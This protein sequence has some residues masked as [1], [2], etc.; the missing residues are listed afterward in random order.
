MIRHNTMT[1]PHLLSSLLL[2][3]ALLSGCDREQ[4]ES[5][6]GDADTTAQQDGTTP[7]IRTIEERVISAWDESD[8]VDSPVFWHQDDSTAIVIAT[9]KETDQLILYDATNGSEVGRVGKSGSGPGEFMRPNG[10][11]LA[12]DL[13]FVV[14]RDN[15][16]V[17][18]LHLPEFTPLGSFGTDDL[19]KPYGIALEGFEGDVGYAVVTDN[20]ETETGQVPSDSLLDRRIRRYRITVKG[21]TLTTDLVASFGETEGDGVLR[22]VESIGFDPEYGRMLVVE[23]DETDTH[24]KIYGID[25]QYRDTTFGRGIH[26]AQTEGIALVECGASDGYWIA[27]DQSEGDNVF[28]LYDRRTFA[29]LGGFRGKRVSNTDGIAL[30]QRPF[31]GYPQGAF[32]A[33]DN[34]GG[35][36][37]F[38]LGEVLEP[39]GCR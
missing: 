6:G 17:Q 37:V 38:D 11:A 33:V 12:G 31:P 39:Y 27:T 2:A 29:H 3:L 19:T 34:D 23:E 1:S 8:N 13:L 32:A 10:I 18:V 36:V 9:A 15:R 26:S 4:E 22:I 25:G 7:E 16:R 24:V 35:V 5:G 14:E 20:Y 28:H 21:Q 30:T